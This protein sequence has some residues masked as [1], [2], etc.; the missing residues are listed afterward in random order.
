[1]TTRGRGLGTMVKLLLLVAVVAAGASALVRD[2]RPA[3]ASHTLIYLSYSSTCLTVESTII[4]FV[5]A[6]PQNVYICVKDIDNDPW[7]AAS[8]NLEMK[9]ISW[10]VGVNSVEIDGP[11]YA[12]GW[13]GSTGRAS[14]C[15][16]VTIVPNLEFGNG[17]VYGGCQTV[18]TNPPFG[19]LSN[20]VLGKIVLQ[21]GIV[22][23]AT[24]IDM[25]GTVGQ[26]TTG[27]HLVSAYFD[28][29]SPFGSVLIPATALLVPVYI[30][31]CADYVPNPPVGD[32]FV[33]VQDI[34]HLAQKFGRT[35]NSP[36]P[37]D[38]NPNWDMDGNN[39]VYVQDILIGA[40]Q[41]GRTCPA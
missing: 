5:G 12:G 13:L 6:P 41:F 14:Q 15:L 8:F 33:G 31:P 11:S 16:P 9:Y 19:P 25:R 7:G 29:Q 37:P 23:S 26:P 36:P 21:P 38:W 28:A 1:M 27:T 35:I 22:K 4:T 40:K 30:A 34:L 3:H 2:G 32:N 17:R 18:G 10:L 20:A 39:G 24:S